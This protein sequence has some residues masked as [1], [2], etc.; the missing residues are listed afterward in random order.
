M[1]AELV[2]LIKSIYNRCVIFLAI[3]ENV[4]LR[5]TIPTLLEDLYADAQVLALNYC[6][7]DDGD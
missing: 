7:K 6:V 5:H 4:N 2:E 3:Y 1:D